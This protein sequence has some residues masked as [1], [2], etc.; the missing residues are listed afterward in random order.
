MILFSLITR[1]TTESVKSNQNSVPE[2]P[3]QIPLEFTDDVPSDD[4]VADTASVHR[5]KTFMAFYSSCDEMLAKI[6]N[7]IILPAGIK[8]EE[9][10]PALE[11]NINQ[12]YF[13]KSLESNTC[14]TLTE[15]QSQEIYSM[16]L[17]FQSHDI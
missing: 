15:K 17:N 1:F 6:Y 16:L 8:E 12:Q 14:F 7:E 10:A 13:R 4:V 2:N 9:I 3:L 11:E 5:E